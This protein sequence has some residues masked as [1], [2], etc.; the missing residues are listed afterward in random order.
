L[1]ARARPGATEDIVA[2][3]ETMRDVDAEHHDDIFHLEN[4]RRPGPGRTPRRTEG[5][6]MTTT[7]TALND[8]LTLEIER[9]D[10]L[11]RH[12][13]S[14]LSTLSGAGDQPELYALSIIAHE[15]CDKHQLILE[16]AGALVGRAERERCM[17][18]GA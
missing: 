18:G 4:G 12:I 1:A 2:A 5:R 16:K 8:E 7:Q 6:A 13:E 14:R 10:A 9:A 11:S 3:L 17:K 15:V